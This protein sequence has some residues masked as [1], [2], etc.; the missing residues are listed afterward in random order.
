[1]QEC[2]LT[3]ICTKIAVEPNFPNDE[4]IEMYLCNSHGSFTGMFNL[5]LKF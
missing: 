3:K 5:V 1:M 2:W 4:I